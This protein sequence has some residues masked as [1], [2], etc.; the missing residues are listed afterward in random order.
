MKDKI[1]LKGGFVP[2]LLTK[3]KSIDKAIIDV[4]KFQYD[5][6]LDYLKNKCTKKTWFLLYRVLL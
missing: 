2:T 5:I 3:K 6:K 1:I 4:E